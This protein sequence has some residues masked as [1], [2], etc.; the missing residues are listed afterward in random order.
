MVRTILEQGQGCIVEEDFHIEITYKS[1]FI[2]GTLFSESHV[3]VQFKVGH[4]QVIE[5]LDW[6]VLGLQVGSKAVIKCSH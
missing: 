5:S 4:G 6:G 2:D 3:P 1:Y